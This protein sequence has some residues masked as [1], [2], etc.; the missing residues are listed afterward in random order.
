MLRYITNSFH[1]TQLI[2][3]QLALCRG[4]TYAPIR[5]SKHAHLK[6][7]YSWTCL[8]SSKRLFVRIGSTRQHCIS[9][10]DWNTSRVNFLGS[11]EIATQEGIELNLHLW[12]VRYPFFS[13]RWIVPNLWELHWFLLY[14]GIDVYSNNG[15]SNTVLWTAAAAGNRIASTILNFSTLWECL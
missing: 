4:Q 15:F 12:P 13:S 5:E 11:F 1:S 14:G 10:E 8:V 3:A 2:H 7:R 6:C 9:N